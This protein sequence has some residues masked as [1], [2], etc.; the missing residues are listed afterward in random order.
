V[1]I[2]PMPGVDRDALRRCLQEVTNRLST[3]S[4]GGNPL[5]DY[6]PDCKVS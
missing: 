4:G 5:L 2:A 1:L 6:Q 3:V